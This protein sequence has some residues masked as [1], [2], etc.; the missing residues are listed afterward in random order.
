MSDD[1][2]TSD[3][4]D[5]Y[6]LL[7]L[8]GDSKKIAQY[9]VKSIVTIGLLILG[10]YT[11]RNAIHK[12]KDPNFVKLGLA[13]ACMIFAGFIWGGVLCNT[14][15]DK[16]L[17]KSTEACTLYNSCSSDSEDLVTRITKAKALTPAEKKASGSLTYT[18]DC[19]PTL[20]WV[21][22]PKGQVLGKNSNANYGPEDIV[23]SGKAC[24][25]VNNKPI[26]VIVKGCSYRNQPTTKNFNDGS[27]EVT[28]FSSDQRRHFNLDDGIV[29]EQGTTFGIATPFKDQVGDNLWG[30][31]TTEGDLK[32]GVQ[33]VKTVNGVREL[34]VIEDENGDEIPK[35]K[36]DFKDEEKDVIKEKT[37]QGDFGT[38]ITETNKTRYTDGTGTSST[39]GAY[40]QEELI[41]ETPDGELIAF[42]CA[43]IRGRDCQIDLGNGFDFKDT[44]IR[45][46]LNTTETN[47]TSYTNALEGDNNNKAFEDSK[48]Q[49]FCGGKDGA[50]EQSNCCFASR[51]SFTNDT[52]PNCNVETTI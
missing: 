33:D 4:K 14:L 29:P 31:T 9:V 22:T 6:S 24:I 47:N 50:F 20:P 8:E 38:W 41:G 23:S 17:S 19:C 40:R 30:S 32:F 16:R 25:L 34:Q 43:D 52:D 1:D 21:I 39:E 35:I 15:C 12:R 45:Q 2:Y 48:V 3:K 28:T 36:G 11:G 18:G 27:E 5:F 44:G 13:M 26:Q 49:V 10:F 51:S 46:L 37:I 42:S 7:G